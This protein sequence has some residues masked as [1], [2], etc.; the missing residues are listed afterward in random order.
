MLVEHESI[1]SSG[2]PILH[3]SIIMIHIANNLYL[4]QDDEIESVEFQD[5]FASRTPYNPNT[6]YRSSNISNTSNNLD[7]YDEEVTLPEPT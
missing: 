5:D 6:E 4:D 7:Y 1:Q 2:K 3:L